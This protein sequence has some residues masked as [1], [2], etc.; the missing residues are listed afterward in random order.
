[1]SQ[2][3]RQQTPLSCGSLLGQ[4]SVVRCQQVPCKYRIAGPYGAPTHHCRAP[5]APSAQLCFQM[6]GPWPRTCPYLC[7]RGAV[8]GQLLLTGKQGRRRGEDRTTTGTATS[9]VGQGR[10][11]FIL[12][13][14]GTEMGREGLVTM[15]TGSLGPG[16]GPCCQWGA[17]GL[18]EVHLRGCVAAPHS[19]WGLAVLSRA[20]LPRA[21]AAIS[22]HQLC[23]GRH[24]GTD[25]V[26]VACLRDAQ[27]CECAPGA[28]GT[29][30]PHTP[31]GPPLPTLP[32][33]PGLL[34][35]C[36]PPHPLLCQ[37]RP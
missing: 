12:S 11:S 15:S 37:P 34:R 21:E 3:G 32:P 1:M 9:L 4:V 14:Q 35:S 33:C 31:Q 19:G 27:C 10:T 26:W 30:D 13:A 18:S 20:R 28:R 23:P 36:A 6:T 16:R 22:P 24:P 25:R 2:G 8:L 7:P 17:P 29:W 5:R